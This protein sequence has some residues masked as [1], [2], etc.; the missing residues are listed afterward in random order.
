MYFSSMIV[1]FYKCPMP[2]KS[3]CLKKTHPEKKNAFK[4]FFC[5]FLITTLA[6]FFGCKYFFCWPDIFEYTSSQ[7]LLLFKVFL[8]KYQSTFV[9][10]YKINCLFFLPLSVWWRAERFSMLNLISGIKW[11]MSSFDYVLV[12]ITPR[13]TLLTVF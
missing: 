1:Y 12:L 10:S 3:K 7:S 13:K 4:N 2:K 8:L 5:A 9:F 6:T 11:A